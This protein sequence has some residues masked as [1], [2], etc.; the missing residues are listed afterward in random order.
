MWTKT[1]GLCVLLVSGSAHAVLNDTLFRT[2]VVAGIVTY[3]AANPYGADSIGI[4]T[5]YSA[6]G[7]DLYAGRL[8]TRW[9]IKPDV[10]VSGRYHLDVNLYFNLGQ[11]NLGLFS[12]EDENLSR[13]RT[14]NNVIDLYSAYRHRWQGFPLYLETNLGLAYF[15]ATQLGN[16]RYG[17]HGQFVSGATLGYQS[18]E[19]SIGFQIKFQHYSDN[20]FS[21]H[22]PGTNLIFFTIEHI[23]NHND[24]E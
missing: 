22:N 2:A 5:G 6:D 3:V 8:T 13:F 10:I 9:K 18:D 11:W 14:I 21:E 24:T 1:L 4:D 16:T 7:P 19:S 17:T 23:F 20:D 12:N 15:S